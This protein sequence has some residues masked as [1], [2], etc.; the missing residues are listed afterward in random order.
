MRERFQ[1]VGLLWNTEAIFPEERSFLGNDIGDI[2]IF[3]LHL[4]DVAIVL[5]R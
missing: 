3:L 2:I 5:H 1:D 4:N